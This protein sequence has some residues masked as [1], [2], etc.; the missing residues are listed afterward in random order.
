MK[1]ASMPKYNR[2]KTRNNKTDSSEIQIQSINGV[3]GA[4]IKDKKCYSHIGLESQIKA[5]QIK[6][7]R[8]ERDNRLNF[9]IK[10]HFFF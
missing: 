3:L 10:L 6:E 8:K 2:D 7:N 5:F 9:Q 4:E 1:N